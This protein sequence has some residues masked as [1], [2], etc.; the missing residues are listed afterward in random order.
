MVGANDTA[1]TLRR[2][3]TKCDEMAGR[4]P[5]DDNADTLRLMAAD[6]REMADRLERKQRRRDQPR[7]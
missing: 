6:Y 4:I 2:K 7:V 5:S 3:A 1:E